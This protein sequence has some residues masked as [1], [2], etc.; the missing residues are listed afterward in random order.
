MDKKKFMKRFAIW[1]AAVVAVVMLIIG[2]TT[3]KVV[4]DNL[5]QEI[6]KWIAG[7]VGLICVFEV[8]AFS[9]GQIIFHWIDCYKR[10]YGDKWLV[11]GIKDDWRAFKAKFSWKKFFKVLGYFVAFFAGALILFWIIG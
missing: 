8:F 6:F 5:T 3:G 1:T 11:E 4:E 2:L 7:T 10:I 9:V